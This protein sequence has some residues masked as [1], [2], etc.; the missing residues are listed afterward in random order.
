MGYP[1]WERSRE[2]RDRQGPE[3]GRW[4]P[5]HERWIPQ[6]RAPE[7]GDFGIEP[8]QAR[9]DPSRPGRGHVL[10]YDE[11]N[12][13]NH[14]RSEAPPVARRRPPRQLPGGRPRPREDDEDE[15]DD[16]EEP[17]QRSIYIGSFISTALW[18]LIPAAA[19]TGWSMTQSAESRPGCTNAFGLPCPAP[20]DEALSNLMDMVPMIAVAMA[21]SI[22]FAMFL[23]RVTTG[24]RP[25]AIGFSSSVLGAGVATVAFAVLKTQL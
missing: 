5:R 14:P 23:G 19:Y 9:S 20:R 22:T 25:F 12:T 13:A 1:E 8:F 3:T 21:L 6:Q 4:D 15:D 18:Y 24:W 7:G 16:E 11:W 2:G 17:D 10:D